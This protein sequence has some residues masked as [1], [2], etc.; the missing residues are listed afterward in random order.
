[1]AKRESMSSQ[2]LFKQAKKYLVGG[3]SSPARSFSYVGGRP[4]LIE[5][6]RGSK[7]YDYDGKSYIDYVLSWGAAITGHREPAVVSALKRQLGFGLGFGTTNAK[8]VALAKEI[9]AAIPFAEKIRFVNSGSE[10]VMAA[11]RLARGYTARDK[12]LKFE[13]AYHGHA[14]YLL[15]KGGSGLATLSIA[16]SAGVP[17]DFIRH[18]LV[19]PINDAEAVNKIFKKY[20]DEIAAVIIEPVGA[21]YGVIPPDLEFLRLLRRLTEKF[22]VLLVFDEVITGFR[23]HYGAAAQAFGVRPDLICLGKVIGGGLP[24][25]AYAGKEEIMR[26]LAPQGKVYQAST[27]SGNPLVMQAGLAALNALKKLEGNYP[28][29]IDLT[30]YLASGLR[31]EAAK[32]KINLEVTDYGTMFSIKFSDR[33]KFARFYRLMLASGVYFAPSEYEANFLSFAHT[34][35][36]IDQTINAAQKAF[37]KIDTPR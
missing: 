10:A 23:F 4:V 8:E 21:N 29:L 19:S 26:Q 32:R 11:L 33:T 1:M 16:S 34:R 3:V 27:F 17:K 30:G 36:D 5:K 15:V 13:N 25:G 12:I 9:Q 14:D 37:H 6:G 28:G 20:A 31:Q 18:T 2:Q 35:K 7:A 22:G 24:I